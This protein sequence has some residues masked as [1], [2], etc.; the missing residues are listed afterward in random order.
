MKA[1]V[2]AR[3]EVIE[4]KQSACV[5]KLNSL[6]GMYSVSDETMPVKVM[7]RGHEAIKFPLAKVSGKPVQR[8]DRGPGLFTGM[9]GRR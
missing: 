9:P 2:R 8:K 7:P 6:A 1:L 4:E 5:S 3:L